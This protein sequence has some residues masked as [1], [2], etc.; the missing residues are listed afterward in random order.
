MEIVIALGAIAGMVTALIGWIRAAQQ[1]RDLRLVFQADLDAQRR[2]HDVERRAEQAALRKNYEQDLATL[3]AA[4]VAA[5][6]DP[7]AL[8]D[9]FNRM[10]PGGSDR[11]TDVARLPGVPSSGS[12]SPD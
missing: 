7:H 4:F 1:K 8:T 9:L 3:R 11:R 2:K 12:T 5:K 10:Q 6:D